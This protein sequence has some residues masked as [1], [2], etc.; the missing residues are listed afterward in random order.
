MSYIPLKKRKED[1]GLSP[2]ELKFRGK[3]KEN[4]VRVSVFDFNDEFLTETQVKDVSELTVYKD[5]NDTITWINI[6]GLDNR[7]VMESMANLFDIPSNV[8][9]NVMDTGLRPQI[10]DFDNGIHISI[11]MLTF[12][13]K[14]STVE[15]ENVSLILMKNV[16]IT[17]QEEKGDVFDPIRERIRKSKMKIR[18]SGTDYLA[19][20]LLDVIID[21]Y[22][23]ILGIYGE[24]IESMQD[25][26]TLKA[27]NKEVLSIIN[28]FQRE[29]NN[30]SRDIK[31][32]KE[33]ILSLAKLET[34]LIAEE[35]E[36]HFQELT[37]NIRQAVELLDYYRELLYDE[38]D[39]YHS[40]MSTKLNDIMA[41][42]TIY[43]LIFIPITFVAGIYGM[44]FDNMPEL[45]TRNGY[46]ITLGAMGLIA[47][48][49][50]LWFKRKKWL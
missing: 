47:L 24:K 8:M 40:A 48:L 34:E 11:K 18:K 42:L 4:E 39:I 17:F 49:I 2:Y 23:Y 31:P 1:L 32:S 30:L 43:S 21:N 35:N 12:K 13:E 3:K 33:M 22:I 16:V 29:L 14:K 26:M 37:N 25:R 38:L 6:D 15:V 28:L 19:F 44:N 36:R 41:L 20:A 7:Q 50:Y 10:N 27:A 5:K 45:H 46:F 9:S